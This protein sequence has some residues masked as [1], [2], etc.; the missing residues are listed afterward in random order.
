[1]PET[2]EYSPQLLQSLGDQ[3]ERYI[4]IAAIAISQIWPYPFLVFCGQTWI[5]P[6]LRDR[7]L[8]CGSHHID[9]TLCHL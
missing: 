5:K 7:G 4:M 3:Y 9:C 8:E 1:M 2:C 6:G